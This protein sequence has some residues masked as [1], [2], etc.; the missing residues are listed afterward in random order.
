M[1]YTLSLTAEDMDAI[2]FVGHRYFWSDALSAL[3][4]GD[5]H[6][7]E[8]EA[9]A[10]AEAFEADTEGGHQYFPMLDPNSDLANKLHAFLV[11]IV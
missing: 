5:N 8:A 3:S 11:S 2:A 9:W 1:A 6:L 4:E 7:S 10:F